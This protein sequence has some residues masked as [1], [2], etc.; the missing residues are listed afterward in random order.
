MDS[1]LIMDNDIITFELATHY[2]PKIALAIESYHNNIQE[3]QEAHHP[4]VHLQAFSSLIDLLK[5]IEKPELKSRFLK[6]MLR[7]EHQL[8]KDI[9]PNNKELFAKL[10]LHI[11]QLSH[12]AGRFAN[13]LYQDPFLQSVL[14]AI[15]AQGTE[16]TLL[17][18]IKFWL[19][20]DE[21]IRQENLQNWLN[22]LALLHETVSIYLGILRNS[23]RFENIVLMTHF[24]QK[25]IPPKT[26]CHLISLSLDR[27]L[28]LIPKMQIGQHGLSIR[29]CEASILPCQRQE[30][31]P[32]RLGITQL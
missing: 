26:Q 24:Y 18:Q 29:F 15:P 5:I 27:N 12:I 22:Q 4:L 6:E 3:A 7:L 28:A 9:N 30:Q 17:P 16:N 13:E 25:P 10:Y 11:H 8:S 14:Q 2:L 31:T 32:I 19:S 21:N 20:V 1:R 23:A